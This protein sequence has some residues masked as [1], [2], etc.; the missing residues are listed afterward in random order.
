MGN[1]T[2]YKARL[3]AQSFS[4]KFGIDY[5]EVF[6]PVVRQTT[7]KMLLTIAGSKDWI[8]KHFDAKTAF[9][10][11]ELKENIYMRQPEGNRINIGDEKKVCKLK[12]SIYG[13]K[14]AAKSWND[15]LKETLQ[16]YGFMQ[17]EADSC[18]FA[19]QENEN[20]ILLAVYVDDMLVTG[21]SRKFTRYNADVGKAI[22]RH[23]F[24]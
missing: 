8:V 13:L 23:R 17:G 1:A 22:R 9:I 15:K 21:N 16:M 18:L 12:K 10:N 4:Q 24:R 11:G 5:D 14:Q 20:L 2:K 3:V 6:A 19:K 7:I